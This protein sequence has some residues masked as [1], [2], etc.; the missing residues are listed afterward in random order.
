M[1][2]PEDPTVPVWTIFALMVVVAC[3]GAMW[4]LQ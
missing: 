4:A 1:I 3:W 2:E